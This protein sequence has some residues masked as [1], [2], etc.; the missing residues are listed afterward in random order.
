M[1]H[2]L[3]TIHIIPSRKN[4]KWQ[5][6]T[7]LTQTVSLAMFNTVQT[8][9]ESREMSMKDADIAWTGVC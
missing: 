2:L 7:D 6:I 4:G 9:A 3:D 1:C 5:C 8:I